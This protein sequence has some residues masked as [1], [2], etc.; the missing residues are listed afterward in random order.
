MQQTVL[1]QIILLSPLPKDLLRR[2]VASIFIQERQVLQIVQ[3]HIMRIKDFAM[4]V[5]QQQQ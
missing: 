3:L 2:E 4:K 5:E 1:F